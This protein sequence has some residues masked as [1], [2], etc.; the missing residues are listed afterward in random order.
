MQGWLTDK[1]KVYV[2]KQAPNTLT[3]LIKQGEVYALDAKSSL[4]K[5]V[6]SYYAIDFKEVDTL[7]PNSFFIKE[8]LFIVT[9]YKFDLNSLLFF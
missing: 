4:A 1:Q 5:E 6:S 2:L 7:I 8:T 3:E 9:T